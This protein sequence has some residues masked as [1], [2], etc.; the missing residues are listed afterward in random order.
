MRLIT[1][2]GF[3]RF[4]AFGELGRG[5]FGHKCRESR[6]QA[7]NSRY[8]FSCRG[9][10]KWLLKRKRVR[11]HVWK[12]LH[13]HSAN[14]HREEETRV[15]FG[16]S[17]FP[18]VSRSFSGRLLLSLRWTSGSINPSLK[19]LINRSVH[20]SIN[21]SVDHSINEWISLSINQSIN[22]SISPS[23]D[24]SV[25]QSLNQ[26]INQSISQSVHQPTH[27]P[28]TDQSLDQSMHYWDNTFFRSPGGQLPQHASAG[29]PRRLLRLRGQKRL[30]EVP[31]D[32]AARRQVNTYLAV[33]YARFTELG[34]KISHKSRRV[35][36]TGE[37]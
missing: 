36:R 2:P 24:Q 31:G 16:W 19:S 10:R 29:I 20:Q 21:Q 32:A 6:T 30:R 34:I 15:D 3:Q 12:L 25:N 22:Q 9:G 37:G 26:P 1:Y 23:V 28:T 11:A 8:Y 14:G 5:H 17:L 7:G 33:L 27:R 4:L 35:I 18:R 13:F